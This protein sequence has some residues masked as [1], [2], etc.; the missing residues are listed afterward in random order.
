MLGIINE[1]YKKVC[2]KRK[3]KFE[4][5]KNCLE[6][7]QIENKINQSKKIKLEQIALKKIEKNLQKTTA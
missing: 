2:H 5:Y 7:I 4:D 3:L 6:P 1:S